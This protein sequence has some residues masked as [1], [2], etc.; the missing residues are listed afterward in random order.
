MTM[1]AVDTVIAV[2]VSSLLYCTAYLKKA[3]IDRFRRHQ[4]REKSS[5]ER[6]G[7]DDFKGHRAFLHDWVCDDEW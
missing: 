2:M 1:L 3:K 4:D 7:L 5:K 6:L